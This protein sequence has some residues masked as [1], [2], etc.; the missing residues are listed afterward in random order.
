M[1]LF[2]FLL[3]FFDKLIIILG[4]TAATDNLFKCLLIVLFV[5]IFLGRCH[6]VQLNVDK[7]LLL[8]L[9]RVVL[10]EIKEIL[11]SLLF[12][13]TLLA[14]QWAKVLFPLLGW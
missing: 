8:V 5:F 9:F 4:T 6:F 1:H 12:E 7:L 11:G 3:Q 2:S 14:S 13:I 10:L